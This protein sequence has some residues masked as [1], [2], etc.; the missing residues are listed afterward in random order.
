M[1]SIA[2]SSISGQQALEPASPI[3]QQEEQN[4][5]EA[6]RE[7]LFGKR[8]AEFH[9]QMESLEQRLSAT[10]QRIESYAHQRFAEIERLITDGERRMTQMVAQEQASR[11][12]EANASKKML[13]DRFGLIHR[14][15]ETFALETAKH[16]EAR[17]SELHHVRQ[18]LAA[19]TQHLR[20]TTPTLHGLA[21]L[22]KHTSDRLRGSANK[23][24]RTEKSGEDLE[25]SV[26]DSRQ[27]TPLV[28]A[29]GF[30]GLPG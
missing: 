10:V 20:E 3:H 24:E 26:T 15:M 6:V 11:H 29:A 7:L 17:R 8:V 14:N 12:A 28:T 30:D 21:D 27:A 4:A 22:F 13:D 5:M 2:H 18:E 16:L 25:T 19:E 23:T 1:D 9:A